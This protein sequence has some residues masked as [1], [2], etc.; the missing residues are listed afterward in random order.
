MGGNVNLV[1]RELTS[2]DFEGTHQC[3]MSFQIHLFPLCDLRPPVSAGRGGVRPTLA[4]SRHPQ[5]VP[6]RDE[7]CVIGGENHDGL[8]DLIGCAEPAERDF[9][10]D[11]VSSTQ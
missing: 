9:V 7:A 6:L 1:A 3:H 11:L 4:R 8:G 5:T 2:P 10:R